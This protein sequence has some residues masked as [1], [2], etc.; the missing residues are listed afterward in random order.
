M[1]P[2]A[3]FFDESVEAGEVTEAYGSFAAPFDFIDTRPP[4]AV[5]ESEST[6]EPVPPEADD[7]GVAPDGE[8]TETGEPFTSDSGETDETATAAPRS[9][10]PGD[11]YDLE[12]DLARASIPFKRKNDPAKGRKQLAVAIGAVVAVV[13]LSRAC[14]H[15][16]DPSLHAAKTLMTKVAPEA[17]VFPPPP[18]ATVTEAP[19]TEPGAEVVAAESGKPSSGKHDALSAPTVPETPDVTPS[20]GPSV[21]RFPDLPPSV[22]SDLAKPFE[23]EPEP[24][25]STAQ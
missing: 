7:S 18:A 19:A 8:E 9:L 12:D 2:R 16:T 4:P 20:N 23:S 6:E 13:L 1:A 17:T 25:Q 21:A 11:E 22:L 5:G 3:V 24:N 10:S 14:M 15:R